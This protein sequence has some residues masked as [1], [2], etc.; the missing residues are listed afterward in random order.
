MATRIERI[1]VDDLDA[2]TDGV[3][4]YRFGLDGVE[5]EIDLSE[6]NLQRLRAALAPFISAG[7]RQPKHTPPARRTASP[8]PR[9]VRAWWAEHGQRH[10]LPPYRAHGP[11]PAEVY[12]TYRQAHRTGAH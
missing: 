12:Q 11:I 8:P 6:P 7:R 1:V 3:G 2:G 9:R 5:Y 10:N 4:T